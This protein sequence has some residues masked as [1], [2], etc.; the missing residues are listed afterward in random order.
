MERKV[1]Y[2]VRL[3]R[4]NKVLVIEGS[5][6]RSFVEN[7]SQIADEIYLTTYLATFFVRNMRYSVSAPEGM[8]VPSIRTYVDYKEKL[9]ARIRN[10]KDK[11]FDEILQNVDSKISHIK[12]F[13]NQLGLSLELKP[14]RPIPVRIVTVKEGDLSTL[15]NIKYLW[16][17]LLFAAN[18][19]LRSSDVN[20]LTSKGLRFLTRVGEKSS[21]G[22]VDEN[23]HKVIITIW[24]EIKSNYDALSDRIKNVIISTY[25]E[26]S[27]ELSGKLQVI[28]ITTTPEVGIK[29]IYGREG[30]GP[31]TLDL[32]VKY[33]P[34]G[35]GGESWLYGPYK[36]KIVISVDKKELI[37]VLEVLADIARNLS[38][39]II[40][41]FPMSLSLLWS[42]GMKVRI[43]GNLVRPLE[44]SW[45]DEWTLDAIRSVFEVFLRKEGL[46][47]GSSGTGKKD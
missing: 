28:D 2:E 7:L 17:D 13:F 45:L 42:D 31:Q 3:D 47:G 20:V 16:I 15:K 24:E 4:R 40:T 30:Y 10:E 44:T 5:T 12:E 43:Q 8:W 46:I 39:G 37:P 29:D 23:L 33:R 1:D 34:K 6:V 18:C 35:T 19:D 25:E 36:F 9:I 27:P 41:S 26:M 14:E 11:F 21:R 22:K 32:A 38:E